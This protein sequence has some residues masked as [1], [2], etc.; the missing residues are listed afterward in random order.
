MMS[1][2]HSLGKP[3]RRE[4]LADGAARGASRVARQFYMNFDFPDGGTERTPSHVK[5][6][7]NFF[8]YYSN[9]RPDPGDQY[10]GD[11][12]VNVYGG[13][14]FK[15]NGLP[16]PADC[17]TEL[18]TVPCAREFEDCVQFNEIELKRGY[19]SCERCQAIAHC[20]QQQ[21]GA[22]CACTR[23]ESGFVLDASNRC[24]AVAMGA[25]T[26]KQTVTAHTMS[27]HFALQRSW[28][29]HSSG[30]TR[31]PV[32]HAQKMQST[33][34]TPPGRK[35]RLI[36]AWDDANW[37]G[38]ISEIE[39]HDDGSST[40]ISDTTM[41]LCLEMG[42]IT[43]TADCSLV[44]VPCLRGSH[45][46]GTRTCH[47]T[48]ACSFTCTCCGVRIIPVCVVGAGAVPLDLARAGCAGRH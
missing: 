7:Q 18:S 25:K 2:R 38:H 35:E 16:L 29:Q 32:Y 4:T 10:R 1:P 48:G 40:L 5:G 14:G 41:P 30:Q 43:T 45:S 42:E 33:A 47:V 46:V 8:F 37:Q 20:T 9:Q 19:C 6:Y 39:I 13:W 17:M 11:G 3:P 26:I 28:A 22:S 36:T 27:A 44:T 23:C 24:V 34:C 15:G 31:S 12:D 21:A